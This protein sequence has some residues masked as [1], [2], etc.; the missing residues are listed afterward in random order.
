MI[1]RQVPHKTNLAIQRNQKLYNH[2][3]K[4][5]NYFVLVISTVGISVPS[6]FC[7]L[8][9]EA[10]RVFP[11]LASGCVLLEYSVFCTFWQVNIQCS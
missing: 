4:A 11:I 9:I 8:A 3:N 1:Y 2:S 7:I 10:G 5:L 6:I